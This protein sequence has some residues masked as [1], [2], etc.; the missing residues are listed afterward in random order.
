MKTQQAATTMTTMPTSFTGI[1]NPHGPLSWVTR[2]L[3]GSQL[4][5]SGRGGV[6][7]GGKINIVNLVVTCSVVLN[8]DVETDESF[9]ILSLI[10]I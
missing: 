6:T 4:G 2:S 3:L 5:T 9:V 10:H 1:I 8:G 7:M